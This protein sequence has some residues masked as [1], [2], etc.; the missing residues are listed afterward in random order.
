[1][2]AKRVLVTGSSGYIGGRLVE[3]LT[4]MNSVDR[5]VGVD[6]NAPEFEH[7]K[8]QF[9]KRDVRDPM[10]DIFEGERID[11]VFHLCWILPPIHNK[12]LMEDINM[13]G[14]KNVLDAA[15]NEDFGL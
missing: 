4:D 1:M 9:Y 10:D 7:P 14:T 3:A 13:G 12:S 15:A 6:L 11:T 2:K 8:L 5:V